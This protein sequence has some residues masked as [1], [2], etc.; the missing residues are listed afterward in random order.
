M[1]KSAPQ[2]RKVSPKVDKMPTLPKRGAGKSWQN[3]NFARGGAR[4]KVH[5]KLPLARAKVHKKLPVVANKKKGRGGRKTVKRGRQN[6]RGKKQ[7]GRQNGRGK[8]QNGSKKGAAKQPRPL[9]S[10]FQVSDVICSPH[11]RGWP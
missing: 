1:T 4:A 3:V 8:K 7:R 9:A 6:A 10:L 5:K 11:R 2:V